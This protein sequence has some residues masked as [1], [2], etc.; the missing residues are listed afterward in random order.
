MSKSKYSYSILHYVH[1]A[2]CG[3][4]INVAVVVLSAIPRVVQVKVPASLQ[5]L[6]LAYPDCD[7][8]TLKNSLRALE[9]RLQGYFQTNSQSQL[10]EALECV[11]PLDD[12]AV[13]PS[14]VGV[15]IANDLAVESEYLLERFVTRYDTD[16]A[17]AEIF[18]NF[19]A[20][21]NWTRRPVMAS[22][23]NVNSWS[24]IEGAND[25]NYLARIA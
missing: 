25:S 9:L 3:E 18:Q 15:G 24:K 4:R 20:P 6:K 16:F 14:K 23:G 17:D 5:R 13:V 21:A 10:G 11:L 12:R 8:T 7:T 19:I 2:Y 1:D 22:S